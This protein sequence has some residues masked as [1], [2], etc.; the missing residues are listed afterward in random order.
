MA[1]I[2]EQVEAKVREQVSAASI[3]QHERNIETL[4][5]TASG[6]VFWDEQPSTNSWLHRDDGT[7]TSIYRTGTGS[8]ACNCDA[9]AKGDVPAEWAGDCDGIG[10]LADELGA[11][12]EEIEMGFFADEVYLCRGCGRP[13]DECSPNPCPSVVADRAR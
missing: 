6:E 11:K 1:S 7:L 8:V 3:K 10:E 2:R 5:A 12:V 13:E 4:Y 9:C